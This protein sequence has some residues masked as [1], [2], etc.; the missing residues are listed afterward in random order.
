MEPMV[1]Q[2]QQ[3]I[4]VAQQQQT[5]QPQTPVTAPQTPVKFAAA[6]ADD[7]LT[8]QKRIEAISKHLKTDLI[9]SFKSSVSG[10]SLMGDATNTTANN[11]P[12]IQL[13]PQ[14][15]LL[16]PQQMS[17][18]HQ[19]QANQQSMYYSPPS[20]ASLYLSMVDDVSYVPNLTIE[21]S[22]NTMSQQLNS[23]LLAGILNFL[24]G[25]ISKFLN[26]DVN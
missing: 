11:S 18:S 5:A 23:M 4:A 1:P 2:P 15:P 16:P 7:D 17:L 24:Y 20:N 10:L 25:F 3:Q 8:K 21:P 13:Q 19:N 14:Q 22:S 6:A 26:R 9:E 12:Q